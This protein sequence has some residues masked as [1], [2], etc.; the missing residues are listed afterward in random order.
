MLRWLLCLAAAISVVSSASEPAGCSQRALADTLVTLDPGRA[1]VWQPL[2]GATIA[3]IVTGNAG[4]SAANVMLM[5]L[6]QWLLWQVSNADAAVA[7][8]VQ[9]GGNV[10][11]A[12]RGSCQEQWV[13]TVSHAW[14]ADTYPR[15]QPAT[16]HVVVT[17]AR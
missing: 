2:V 16:V 17:G 11:V 6:K 14:D 9:P 7:H 1:A 12:Q 5:P 8:R 10:S 13:L 4:G 3:V 15:P